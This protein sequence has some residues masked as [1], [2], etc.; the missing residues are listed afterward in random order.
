L[1]EVESLKKFLLQT[2]VRWVIHNVE[3]G[4]RVS[5]GEIQ[6]L[7]VIGNLRTIWSNLGEVYSIKEHNSEKFIVN[8]VVDALSKSQ[9]KDAKVDLKIIKEFI[10]QLA[11]GQLK[12]TVTLKETGNDFMILDG[13]KSTTAYFE[14]CK[15]RGENASLPVFII[16]F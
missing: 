8:Q 10:N 15:R 12:L 9:N 4:A 1:E 3:N 2:P 11:K 7:S 5:K 16:T 14:Y 13:N 6:G